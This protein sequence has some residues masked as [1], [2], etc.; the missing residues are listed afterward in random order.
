VRLLRPDSSVADEWSYAKAPKAGISIERLPDGGAWHADG[1]PTPGLPNQAAPGAGQPGDV[2]IAELRGWPDGAWASVSGFVSV[3]PGL[4]S[5]RTIHIQ[6]D[7]GGLTV[8]L[9]RNEW[10]PLQV[11]QPIRLVLGYLRHRSGDLQLYLRNAWHIHAGSGDAPVALSAWEVATGDVGEATEGELVTVSGK[12]VG[13][14]PDAFRL[15]DGS[16]AARVFLAAGTGLARPPMQLGQLWQVTGVVV[17]NA[18]ASSPAPAYRLQPRFAGDLAQIVNGQAVP[19]A[20]AAA[21][22]ATATPEATETTQP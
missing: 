11:G 8:Y 12:V 22:L 21:A 14:E 5:T 3:P 2:S 16:G 9:G 10:P 20:P 15:D 4:F 1:L 7:T 17:E 13:L 18:T 6:D 19:Y